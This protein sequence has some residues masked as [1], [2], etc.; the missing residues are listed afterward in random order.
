MVPRT[1]TAVKPC[2]MPNIPA[3]QARPGNCDDCVRTSRYAR[4]QMAGATTRVEHQAD[5]VPT[6]TIGQ[7]RPVTRLRIFGCFRR[8]GGASR[9]TSLSCRLRARQV[10]IDGAPASGGPG[11]TDQRSVSDRQL[12]ARLPGRG[13]FRRRTGVDRCRQKLAACGPVAEQQAIVTAG[14]W[15]RPGPFIGASTPV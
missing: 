4:L 3:H 13:S 12:T 1:P 10:G 15:D 9:C 2:R 7:P 14:S 11:E 8:D 6:L 5:L